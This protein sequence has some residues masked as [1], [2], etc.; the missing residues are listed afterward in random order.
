MDIK[1][2]DILTQSLTAA[3]S[4][5]SA[6]A[7]VLGGALGLPGVAET[8]AKKGKGKKKKKHSR[9]SSPP[10]P[11]PPS[12]P[13]PPLPPVRT[14]LTQTFTN[15]GAIPIPGTG[16][17]GNANPYPSTI[18]VSGLT[19]GVITD[20]NVRLNDFNHTFPDDADILLAAP[21]ISGRQ[22]D[23]HERRRFRHRRGQR[24]PDAGRCGGGASAGRW[25]PRQRH[26]PTD[27]LRSA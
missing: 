18:E 9:N 7:A 8:A 21:H 12:P 20:V 14:S 2:F 23:R 22:R 4:R 15:S 19:N 16:T 11:P 13:P 27:Q 10:S 1:R 24:Q 25:F 3:C 6:L 17:L 5:R 26:V